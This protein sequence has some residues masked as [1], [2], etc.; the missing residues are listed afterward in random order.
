M[1]GHQ[2]SDLDPLGHRQ[3]GFCM[4]LLSFGIARTKQ[5]VHLYSLSVHQTF[6]SGKWFWGTLSMGVVFSQ[7]FVLCGKWGWGGWGGGGGCYSTCLA[8]ID[9]HTLT[10]PHLSYC[11]LGLQGIFCGTVEPI[12]YSS[13]VKRVSC[14]TVLTFL[15]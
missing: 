5:V 9:L 8:L 14:K 7:M 2:G 13:N 1:L 12:C 10:S 11:E 15:T 4:V 3:P 6:P